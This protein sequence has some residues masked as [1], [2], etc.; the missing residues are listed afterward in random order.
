MLSKPSAPFPS[1]R[2]SDDVKSTSIAC[3]EINATGE[4]LNTL[5]LFWRTNNTQSDDVNSTSIAAN[6]PATP[7]MCMFT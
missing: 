1:S 3:A 7:R 6:T 4:C 2:K 5:R